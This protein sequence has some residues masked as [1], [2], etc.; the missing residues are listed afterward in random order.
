METFFKV[1]LA[2]GATSAVLLVAAGL[3]RMVEFY[4]EH[5][6]DILGRWRVK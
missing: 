5:R 1:V 3:G 4:F 6:G 2:V